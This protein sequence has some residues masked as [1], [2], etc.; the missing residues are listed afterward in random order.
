MKAEPS[1]LI[2]LWKMLFESDFWDEDANFTWN[3][4]PIK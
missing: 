4:F 1:W 2:P 3:R